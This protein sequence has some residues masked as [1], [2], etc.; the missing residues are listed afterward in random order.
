[1]KYIFDTY[2][3]RAATSKVFSFGRFWE[4]APEDIYTYGTK[5]A[6]IVTITPFR[7]FASNPDTLTKN[8]WIEERGD[9]VQ[10]ALMR[11]RYDP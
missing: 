5:V 6:S 1:M 4:E 3:A 7:I 8:D 2:G 9:K 10:E 11:A